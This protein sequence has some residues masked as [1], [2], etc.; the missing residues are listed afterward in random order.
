M[1]QRCS[2]VGCRF[3]TTP[4]AVPRS[5]SQA[6]YNSDSVIFVS[7]KQPCHAMSRYRDC[8]FLFV[9]LLNWQRVLHHDHE[10]RLVIELD[11]AP[12]AAISISS[13]ISGCS[14]RRPLSS[15]NWPLSVADLVVGPTHVVAFSLVSLTCQTLCAWNI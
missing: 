2:L 13:G 3:E 7:S 12:R 8:L 5:H 15:V 14:S 6:K 9:L 10:Q 1:D 4:K 11:M